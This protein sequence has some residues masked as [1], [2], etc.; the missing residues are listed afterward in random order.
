MSANKAAIRIL[1]AISAAERG[2]GMKFCIDC[3]YA[4]RDASGALAEHP[5]CL[6]PKHGP[7]IITDMVTGDI[8]KRERRC[9]DSRK[10]LIVYTKSTPPGW[11]G[12]GC[13]EQAQFFEP[14]DV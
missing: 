14:R 13:G 10:W 7:I 12:E 6:H 4:E 3:K 8:E 2:D 5:L 9:E 11:N 1:D